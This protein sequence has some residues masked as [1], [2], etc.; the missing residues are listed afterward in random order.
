MSPPDWRLAF[1]LPNLR[2]GQHQ[3]SPAELSLGL[4]GIA[5]VAAFDPRVVAIKAIG[6]RY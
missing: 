3:R 1:I 2:L 4:E 6:E 5:I